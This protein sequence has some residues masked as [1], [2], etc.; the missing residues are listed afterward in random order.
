M[1][2][3]NASECNEY[4]WGLIEKL[5]ANS[6]QDLLNQFSG[7][8]VQWIDTVPEERMDFAYAEGKWTVKELLQHVIDT[9]RVFA[10]RLLAIARGEKQVLPP[11]EENDYVKES[12]MS[13]KSLVS[14]QK[15]FK[16]QRLS[17]DLLIA[18]LSEDILN[19]RGKVSNY[20]ITARALS[21]LIFAHL[22]HH[23]KVLKDRYGV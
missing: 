15:E 12:R 19:R 20:E 3:P 8:L 23:V 21:F 18:S 4:Q 14:I 7:L 11:F 9:E 10:Y 5:E 22:L 13:E 17:T 16:A 2:K 1:S 6:T